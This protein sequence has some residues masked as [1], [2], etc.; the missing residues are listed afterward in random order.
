MNNKSFF[1]VYYQPG[2][3]PVFCYRSGL[4]VYEEVFADGMLVPGGYNGA[5]YPQNVL[6]N[7][8]SR[9]D[10]GRFAEPYAFDIEVNGAQIGFGLRF[11]DFTVEKTVD[12]L[13]AILTLDSSVQPIRVFVHTILDGTQ[14]FTRWL[15]LENRSDAPL[16]ISRMGILSGGLETID[17]GQVSAPPTPEAFY[18][19]GYFDDDEWGKEGDF[20][21]H[22]LMPDTTVIDESGSVRSDGAA[23][24]VSPQT[25][26]QSR[27]T[28]T[29]RSLSV[30]RSPVMH[31]FSF[32]SL[33]KPSI[34]L[35]FTWAWS[36][37]ILTM[38]STKCMRTSA[39]LF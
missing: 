28:V 12:S 29:V 32:C 3:R 5:G 33:R 6:T 24:V 13:H 21:W 22:P 11:I 23:A 34:R 7:C 39:G 8:P 25:T 38:R 15:T 19:L 27:R 2:D 18:S 26:T 20:S 17:R 9:L 14:M 36:A 16:N 31:R 37:A 4:M 35:R 10:S 30:P 1:D